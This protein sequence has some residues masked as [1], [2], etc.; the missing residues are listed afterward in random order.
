MQLVHLCQTDPRVRWGRR[1]LPLRTGQVHCTRGQSE[2]MSCPSVLLGAGGQADSVSPS[3]Q[4]QR[5]EDRRSDPNASDLPANRT[6][7]T[8]SFPGDAKKLCLCCSLYLTLV[9]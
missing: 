2:R 3:P 4:T 1:R 6:D 5:P 7:G 9:L 8:R